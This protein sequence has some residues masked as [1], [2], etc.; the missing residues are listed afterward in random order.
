MRAT[1]TVRLL[2]I[3]L[4]WVALNLLFEIGLGRMVL[5]L[6]WDRLLEDY[7]LARGGFFGLGLLF[8]AVSPLL[9]AKVAG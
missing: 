3:G 8:M 7:D 2:V 9:A 6:T 5:D 1:T 4:M